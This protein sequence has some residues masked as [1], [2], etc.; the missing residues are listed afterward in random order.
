MAPGPDGVPV[1]FYS[2]HQEHL[3]SRVTALLAQFTYLETLP[4][5]ML[6][7]LIVLVPKPGKDPKEHASYRFKIAGFTS[8]YSNRRSYTRWS[9]EGH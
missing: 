2:L 9:E 7:A 5:L 1:E 6:E 3:A 4:E 8:S